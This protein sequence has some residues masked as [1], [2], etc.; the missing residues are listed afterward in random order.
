MWIQWYACHRSNLPCHSDGSLLKVLKNSHFIPWS[1]QKLRE[2]RRPRLLNTYCSSSLWPF[3][4]VGENVFD[5]CHIHWSLANRELKRQCGS[6]KCLYLQIW[7]PEVIILL[8]FF[9]GSQRIL[10]KPSMNSTT[11]L[12]LYYPIPSLL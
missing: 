7:G 3:L 9:A 8:L 11:E 1:Q 2:K 4:P 10:S 5:K 12:F 6:F